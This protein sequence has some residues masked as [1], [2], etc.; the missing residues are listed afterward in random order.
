MSEL[1]LPATVAAAAVTFTYFFCVRPM[2]RGTCGMSSSAE[3]NQLDKELAE[4]QSAL[5]R[6]RADQHA[7][8]LTAGDPAGREV[9]RST[10]TT[11][12]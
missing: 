6:M 1:W 5:A 4:A 3:E 8:D 7:S 9:Q 11:E 2:R 12:R 10:P